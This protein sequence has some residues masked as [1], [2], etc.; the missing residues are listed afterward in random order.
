MATDNTIA[1][2]NDK[3][4]TSE[5]SFMSNVDYS[6]VFNDDVP[7]LDEF[8]VSNSFMILAEDLDKEYRYNRFK[9]LVSESFTDTSLGGS[10]SINVTP[11]FTR[12]ADIR[13][14][15]IRDEREDVTVTG[16]TMSGNYGMGRYYGESIDENATL[17]YFELGMFQANNILFHLLSA[18]DYR[19]AVIANSGRSPIFYDTG[20]LIGTTAVFLAFPVITVGLL[21]M[22]YAAS[23]ALDLT[24]GPGRFDHYYLKPTM[25]LYWSTVNSIATMMFT[26]LG[27]LSPMF[28]GKEKDKTRIGVP[29]KPDEADIQ[30]MNRL[31]PGLVTSGNAI[32]VHAMIARTQIA[33]NKHRGDKLKAIHDLSKLKLTDEQ[34]RNYHAKLKKVKVNNPRQSKILWD[35]LKQPIQKDGMYN[36]KDKSKELTKL[37]DDINANINK[38]KDNYLNTF[39]K[40]KDGTIS[41]DGRIEETDGYLKSYKDTTKAIWDEGARFAVFRV[42]HL[43]SSTTSF[44]NSTTNVSLDE[45]VNSASNTWRDLKFNLGGVTGDLATKAAGYLTDVVVGLSDGLTLGASNVVASFLAG[46]NISPDKRWENSTISL[47]T[48]SFK[49]TLRSPSA[50]PVAQLQN[51]Y[52]PAAAVLA[53]VLPLSTGARSYTSPFG[54]NMFVRGHQRIDRGMVTSLSITKGVTN[55][56]YNKQRRTLGLDITFTVTDFSTLTAAPV[57]SDLL[58]SGSVMFDDSSGISRYIQSLCARDLYST[59]HLVDKAKIKAS[60]Y[61]QNHSIMMSQEYWAARTGDI[62]TGLPLVNTLGSSNVSNY[63]QNF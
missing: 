45:T 43:G 63:S 56:A 37:L 6:N 42:E 28:M 51:L 9:T 50:H 17:V 55:L 53:M 35:E 1:N 25:F 49:M 7:V 57:V 4:T 15:D 36:N 8:W 52:I 10:I 60:Q 21:L 12:Y 26:E 62:L 61:F 11:Q 44:S 34:A 20:K 19:T 33:Y 22:K 40:K 31:M 3:F 16:G 32:N 47:P 5:L 30:A 18:V 41:K 38:K 14:S 58:S 13:V 27:V 23:V 29:I 2:I 48:T 39:D 54:C 24:A 59:T 46:A